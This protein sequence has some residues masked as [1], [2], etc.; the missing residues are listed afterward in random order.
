MSPT[1]IFLEALGEPPAY[2]EEKGDCC[3]C[4]IHTEKGTIFKRSSFTNFSMKAIRCGDIAC[5]WCNAFMANTAFLKPKFTHGVYTKGW[6]QNEIKTIEELMNS[7]DKAP[8]GEPLLVMYLRRTSR[9]V[10]RVWSSKLSFSKKV[11]A[12]NDRLP[13][14]IMSTFYIRPDVIRKAIEAENGEELGKTKGK[15]AEFNLSNIEKQMQEPFAALW[16]GGP[17]MLESNIVTTEALP[18]CSES[19]GKVYAAPA[20]KGV[21]YGKLNAFQL[22]AKNGANGEFNPETMSKIDELSRMD[23]VGVDAVDPQER[24]EWLAAESSSGDARVEAKAQAKAEKEAAKKEGRA[25]KKEGSGGKEF[26]IT[27]ILGTVEPVNPGVRFVSGIEINLSRTDDI[28]VRETM[29]ALVIDA[30]MDI[31]RLGGYKRLG[32]GNITDHTITDL[33]SGDPEAFKQASEMREIAEEYYATVTVNE[34][35]DALGSKI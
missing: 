18:F 29:N 31:D 20:L 23:G 27:N 22:F 8:D 33:S 3:F 12:V 15:N 13:S 16:G 9:Q 2:G 32:W 11:I 4:G 24:K 28:G 21:N 10:H 7:I 14:G 34:V 17:L 6:F 1:Q 26:K 35:M 19:A 30:I 25:P 5:E